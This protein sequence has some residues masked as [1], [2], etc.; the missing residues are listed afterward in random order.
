MDGERLTFPL[1]LSA[2]LALLKKNSRHNSAGVKKGLGGGGKTSTRTR[3]QERGAK[4]IQEGK[5]NSTLPAL[6]K[7]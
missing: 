2:P 1:L 4:A 3:R 5:L 7:K 6:L